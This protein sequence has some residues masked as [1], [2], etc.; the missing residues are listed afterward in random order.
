MPDMTYYLDNGEFYIGAYLLE[1]GYAGYFNN[2]T[3]EDYR[4]NPAAQCIAFR[5][6]LPAGC[7]YMSD[8]NGTVTKKSIMLLPVDI[9]IM[10]N[11]NDFFIHGDS[12]ENPGTASKGC[13]ILTRPSREKILAA[14]RPDG[15]SIL[16]VKNGTL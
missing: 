13:I 3:G 6:P 1:T 11:R 4:N 10:C 9:T 5:G 16:E 8:G 15:M 7:Y 12:I 14:L 2:I